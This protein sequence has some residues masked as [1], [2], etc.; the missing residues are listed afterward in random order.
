[1]IFLISQTQV[2]S[3]FLAFVAKMLGSVGFRTTEEIASTWG[4][5]RVICGFP[6]DLWS[7][8]YK[9]PSKEPTNI[10]FPSEVLQTEET[11]ILSKNTNLLE[12]IFYRLQMDTNFCPPPTIYD[13]LMAAIRIGDKYFYEFCFLSVIVPT[14]CT[15]FY[16]FWK[17]RRGIARQLPANMSGDTYKQS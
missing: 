1:M 14:C 10:V 2:K 8:R 3:S 9:S 15:L 17:I 13:L 6:F 12:H 7:M 4:L 16:L 5:S 11:L